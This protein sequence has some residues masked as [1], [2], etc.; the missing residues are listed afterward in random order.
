MMTFGSQFCVYC[1]QFAVV[2]Y[3]TTLVFDYCWCVCQAN[4]R[5]RCALSSWIA[6]LI[7]VNSCESIC[8][9]VCVCAMNECVLRAFYGDDTVDNKPYD[10]EGRIRNTNSTY[11]SIMHPVSVEA[12]CIWCSTPSTEF[13][14]E[15]EQ[16]RYLLFSWI[17]HLISWQLNVQIPITNFEMNAPDPDK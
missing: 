17:I 8:V 2:V 6:C 11:I 1:A 3:L 14:E 16:R 5:E 4:Q 7:S 13:V 10:D 9:C 15:D 12:V